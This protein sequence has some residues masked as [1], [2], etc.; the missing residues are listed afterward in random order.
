MTIDPILTTGRLDTHTKPLLSVHFPVTTQKS[1]QNQQDMHSTHTI[2]HDVTRRVHVASFLA[3]LFF[4]LPVS[5]SC[6]RIPC[7]CVVGGNAPGTT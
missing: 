2:A 4:L 3:F 7:E 6:F 5:S 1:T